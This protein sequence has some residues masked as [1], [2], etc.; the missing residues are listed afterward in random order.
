M[1]VPDLA[2][3][4]GSEEKSKKP[5]NVDLGKVRKKKKQSKHLVQLIAALVVLILIAVVWINADTIFEPLRG[6]ASKIETKTT[7][8]EGY[9]IELTG[10]GNYSIMRFGSNFSLL[11][12]TYLYT[13]STTGAQLYALKH[14][15]SHPEQ[16][17]SEK[18]IMLFDKTGNN[19]SVYSKSSLIYQNS[20][21]DR[22]VYSTI[23]NDGL[24]AVVTDS[25]RYSNVLYIYDDGGNWKYTKKFADENVIKVCSVGDGNHIVVATLS[26]SHGDIITNFY[27]YSITST[28]DC[29]WKC[30]VRSGSL[31]CGMFADNDNVIAI[32]DNSV[33]SIDCRN[34][35]L[36]NSYAYSGQL[37]HLYINGDIALLQYNDISANRNVLTV[38]NNK[39]EATAQ[40]N[41]SASASC[42]YSDASGIYVLDGAKLKVFDIDLINE[43][44]IH[45]TDDDYTDFVKI[46]DDIIML[47][48]ETVNCV[49]I[50]DAENKNEDK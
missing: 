20:V 48:Y 4:T 38:F 3:A 29:V 41:V 9:P 44:D 24:A 25:K 21:D 50:A 26:A 10:S 43:N 5:K 6:I 37:K 23:G 46:G 40:V 47:G 28:E 32:C 12:D 36:N 18:R 39:A 27:K 13:Y 8:T 1:K 11:N 31:P 34:G 45:V 49:N 7:F 42:V 16:A 17:T 30:T 14:G 33:I 2:K 22:I 35:S 15:Y 19:F